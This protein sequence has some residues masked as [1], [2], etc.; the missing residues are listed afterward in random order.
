MMKK[1]KNKKRT[2]PATE[3]ALNVEYQG[4]LNPYLDKELNTLIG[5]SCEDCGYL[6]GDNIRDL[7]WYFKSK[8]GALK[9]QSKVVSDARLLS[10]TV[11]K[12][13]EVINKLIAKMSKSN[14]KN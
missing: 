11:H 3:Y 5:K 1:M 12:D 4:Q 8:E 14:G 9:A 13:Y 7:T 2:L 6:L 10:A